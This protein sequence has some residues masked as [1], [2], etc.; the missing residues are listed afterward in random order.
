MFHKAILSKLAAEPNESGRKH[1]FAH[2]SRGMEAC[3]ALRTNVI[4]PVH[5]C[6][7]RRRSDPYRCRS[8]FPFYHRNAVVFFSTEIKALSN[9]LGHMHAFSTRFMLL[10]LIKTHKML[11]LEEEISEFLF[12]CLQMCNIF[13]H[14]QRPCHIHLLS[15]SLFLHLSFW[16]YKLMN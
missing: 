6:T 1:K 7:V 11:N 16:V 9:E 10:A 5:I 15:P 2:L 4:F 14:T 12:L 3:I 13:P 8:V